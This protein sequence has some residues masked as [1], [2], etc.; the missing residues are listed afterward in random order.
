MPLLLDDQVRLKPVTPADYEWLYSFLTLPVHGRRWVTHGTSP[1][2]EDF[3]RLLWQGVLVQY[4][5][6]T[7]SPA[8]RAALVSAYNA[9]MR[10]GVVYLASFSDP[11]AVATGIAIKG[12]ALLISQLFEQWPIRKI[13]IE[14]TEASAT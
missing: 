10:N 2:P 8:Q 9:S 12:S 5:V 14:V 3:R 6:W 7:N 13:Y 11:S 4:V 1:S